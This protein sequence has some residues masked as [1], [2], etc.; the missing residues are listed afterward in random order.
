MDADNAKG[1]RRKSN[2]PGG[3]VDATDIDPTSS[4]ASVGIGV[5]GGVMDANN[6]G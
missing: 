4:A 2:V 5:P 6:D 3:G 1:C